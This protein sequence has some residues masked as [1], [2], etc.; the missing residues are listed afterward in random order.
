MALDFPLN[1]TNGQTYNGWSYNSS[2]SVW[3]VI[4]TTQPSIPVGSIAMW[5]TATPP[6]GWLL[7]NGQSTSAYPVLAAI[8]GQNVPDLTGR[9]PVGKA[10]SGTFATLGATGGEETHALTPSESAMPSH[11]HGGNTYDGGNVTH[12]H[13]F[14]HRHLQGQ[15]GNRTAT[16]GTG[17]SNWSYGSNTGTAAASLT[18]ADTN[19]YHTINGSGSANGAA[20][21]NLQPYIV[22]NYIIKY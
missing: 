8:V 5:A 11:S 15:G 9:V 7:C 3:E 4:T 14:N 20:H 16:G 17:S 13:T 22:L 18:A 1:P 21:N 19:H 6:S 2:K 12:S 10:S